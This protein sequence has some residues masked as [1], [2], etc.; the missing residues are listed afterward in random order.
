MKIISILLNKNET[1][2]GNSPGQGGI[3]IERGTEDNAKLLFDDT[4]T[5]TQPG[6]GTGPGIFTFTVGSFK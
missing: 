5:Y 4:P 6:G 1:G 2:A 3:E